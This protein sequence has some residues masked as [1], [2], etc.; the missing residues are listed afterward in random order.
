MEP[1]DKLEAHFKRLSHFQHLA[2]IC[3]W[4][5]AT[6]MPDGGNNARADAMAEL[7]LYCHQQLTQ[8]E[9]GDWFADVDSKS[10]S[11]TT[12]QHASLEEM[13]REWRKASVLPDTLVKA[14]S[15]AGAKC[16]HAWRQQRQ[17]NDWQGFAKNLKEVVALAREEAHIRADEKLCSPYDALLDLYEP[18]MTTERIDDVFGALKQWLPETIQAVVDKQTKQSIITPNGPFPQAQQ[19]ALGEQIM[20]Q[21]GFSF[22]HGRLDI[23]THPF[24]GG[25]PTDVRIT[26]RYDEQDF[27]SALMGVIHE[28]GHAR[29]QQGLPEALADLPVGQAR[30]MGVHESQSLFF[31]M[32]LARSASFA[33]LI[34]QQAKQAFNRQDDPAF[35]VENLHRV[36]TQV[37]PGYIRVDADEVT[38]PAHIMLRYDIE[39]DLISGK[40]DVDHIPERWDTEM[41]QYLGLS[42]AGDFKNGCMQDI[43]WTDGSFGYFPTYT[44]GALYAAQLMQ[45]MRQ[46]LDVDGIIASGNLSPIFDWLSQ[47]IWQRA[48]TTSTD[49]LLK[50]ATGETL[51]PAH[52]REYIQGRYL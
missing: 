41:Q 28:T 29:Y 42:T 36:L 8:P 1:L 47:H 32:Q 17:E 14:K 12:T 49:N 10:S 3:G 4:D 19:K 38:Y 13:K 26:T 18:G 37:S 48:S 44:L 9:L 43:H 7:A 22:A 23:S 52:F 6:M 20:K 40:M 39:R 51:N 33:T 35:Q 21:L 31:E 15:L 34:C 27:T 16:E 50:D 2:A 11:L 46:Q 24:C 5:Q 30:S 25:V 45:T